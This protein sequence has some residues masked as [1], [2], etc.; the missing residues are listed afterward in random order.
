MPQGFV[1]AFQILGAAIGLAALALLVS[2]SS[3]A[4][5]PGYGE[6]LDL[7]N[8]TWAAD[9][10]AILVNDTYY[11]YPTTTT[12]SL[13]TWSSTDLV[14]WTYEGVIWEPPDPYGWN[15]GG[16][17]APDVFVDD[18]VYYLYYVANGMIGLAT[19]DSPTGP[20]VDYYDHPFIGGGYG[21]TPDD[22]IDPHVFRGLDGRLYILC[23]A[24][25]ALSL[26]RIS[27]MDDPVTVTGEW[28]IAVIPGLIWEVF[29][30]EGPYMVI[31]DGTYYLM[32]SGNNTAWPWYAIGYATATDPLG[33][34][35]KARENPILHV[36]WDYDFWGPG[37][38]SVVH[39]P[40]GTW[41]LFYHTKADVQE[42]WNRLVRINELSFDADGK[43]F[44]VLADDDD[45]DNDDNDDNDN[46][47]NDDNNDL[48]DDDDDDD[49]LVTAD[50]ASTGDES[51]ACG[52]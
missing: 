2:E 39:E 23:T 21:N 36:D 16:I 52:C 6:P 13:E 29:W 40:G 49:N 51:D 50:D 27:D 17:W 14:N 45:D 7:P 32:Y 30:I 1:R 19:S 35:R 15:N 47:D 12:V 44:V 28:R 24:T 9:P 5:D 31:R 34:Y 4:G 41:R 20:F 46:N 25:Y 18:G 43:M 33:P 26:I 37:H 38:N 22:T 8:S 3:W 42:N 10:S 11:L 48:D